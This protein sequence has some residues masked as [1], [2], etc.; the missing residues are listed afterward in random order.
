MA[1]STIGPVLT[2][3]ALVAQG[4]ELVVVGGCALL[5]AGLRGDCGDLDIVPSREHANLERLVDACASLGVQGL[6]MSTLQR[7][8]IVGVDSPF[9]RIDVLLQRASVEYDALCETG[10]TAM[11]LD[12]A[13]PVAPVVRVLELQ[14]LHRM[15]ALHE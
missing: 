3:A 12:V 1:G 9:G 10:F 7:Q 15:G 5:L 8:P 4:V 11:V 2:A 6:R 13:V 14:R